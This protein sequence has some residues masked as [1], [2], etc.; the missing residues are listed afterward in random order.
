MNLGSERNR[1]TIES[2]DSDN[3]SEKFQPA[4]SSMNEQ[5]LN[6]IQARFAQMQS[7]LNNQNE[8][9][10]QLTAE[11]EAHPLQNLLKT[12]LNVNFSSLLK[13]YQ[14]VNPRKPILS[15]DGSPYNM[16]LSLKNRSSTMKRISFLVLTYSKI[17]PLQP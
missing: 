14:E 3:S 5:T 17:M 13:F 7:I 11:K 9:I 15:F 2:D 8:V 4:S 16:P 6:N 1:R 10:A 12:T